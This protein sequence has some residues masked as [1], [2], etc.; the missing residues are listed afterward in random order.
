MATA[1]LYVDP[2][3][4]DTD[5]GSAAAPLRTIQAALDKATPGTV[6]NLAPGVYREK[7]ATV[8]DGAPGAPITIKGPESGKDRAGRYRATLYGTGRVVSVNHS[9]Y[10][11]DG[12]T[13][14]GQ[15]TAGRH[16]RSRPTSPPSTAFK[17][18]V[19]PQVADGRLI[20]IGAADDTRDLTG[21]TITQ[22]V[23]QRR[24]RRV[25]PAAQQRARQRDHRLG[26]PVL[27]HVRQG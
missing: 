26:H 15:E 21:I 7:L 11:F 8:R 2:R 4:S 6:I 17:N 18:S 19:Q 22:H 23:P 25:R 3:G 24:R 27:R 5:D 1:A 16:A 10:T 9:Y 13:I 12:F 20:Y 14:D